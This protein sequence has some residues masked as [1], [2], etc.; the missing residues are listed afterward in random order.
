MFHGLL[1]VK[2]RQ[3]LR[4]EYRGRSLVLSMKKWLKMPKRGIT[5]P[6]RIFF[7]P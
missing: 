6:W 5:L 3:F 2:P 7:I 1:P 4:L